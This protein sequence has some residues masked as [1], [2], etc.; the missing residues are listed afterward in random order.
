LGGVNLSFA[1]Q[2]EVA[3]GLGIFGINK[4]TNTV[5]VRFGTYSYNTSTYGAAGTAWSAGVGAYYWR[6]RK[7]SAGAAVGFGIVQPGVSAGL[8]SASGLPGRT[9]GAAVA[10]GYVGQKLVSTV[11]NVN[12]SGAGVTTVVG[13]S[14]GTPISIGKWMYIISGFAVGTGSNGFRYGIATTTNST[15]GWDTSAYSNSGETGAVNGNNRVSFHM[16]VYEDVTVAGD[17]FLTVGPN[18]NVTSSCY[19]SFV[20]VRVF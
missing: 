18:S 12:I 8:V 16:V 1:N 6:V 5:V 14:G 19:A 9:D 2:N 4:T 3:Y 17:R 15:T 11:N 20:A 13:H 10:S 7:A